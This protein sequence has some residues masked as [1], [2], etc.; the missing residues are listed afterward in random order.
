MS[1]QSRVR[2][3]GSSPR[4]AG[5]VRRSGAGASTCRSR[6]GRR[7]PR[8][9]PLRR[10]GPSRRARRCVR[11]S[12][13]SRTPR[14][15]IATL[16][17][18]GAPPSARAVRRG[19]PGR[20]RRRGRRRRPP[21]APARRR[22]RRSR[23][24]E[25]RDRGD[26][27][28]RPAGQDAEEHSDDRRDEAEREGL[29]QD[30]P[31]DPRAAPADGAQD[32]DLPRSLEDGHDH[33]VHDPDRADP[34]RQERDREVDRVQ[35]LE[36]LVDLAVV[37]GALDRDKLR[38]FSLERNGDIVRVDSG[39]GDDVHRRDDVLLA[40]DLLCGLQGDDRAR[41]LPQSPVL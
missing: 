36:P 1:L 38:K 39:R 15:S 32:A 31:H 10:R 12:K 29:Q 11:S 23:L 18:N 34:D 16:T 17:H 26:E 13:S 2:R 21:R 8:T 9:R 6:M 27:Q 35:D 41:V 37:G 5:R 20:A 24:E 4:P 33:R 14:T 28:D 40:R 19:T 3:R 30:H 22:R 7:L 25:R